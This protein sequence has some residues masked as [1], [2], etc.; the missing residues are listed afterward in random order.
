M[1]YNRKKEGKNA[2]L[3]RRKRV[4][5]FKTI[6]VAGVV[7]LIG[8]SVIL[9]IVLVFKVLHLESQINKLYSQT[10]VVITQNDLKLG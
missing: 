8:T 2:Q 5:R 10:P 4:N 6:I 1:S 7:I 9:N 3:A